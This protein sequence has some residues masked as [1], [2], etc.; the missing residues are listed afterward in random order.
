MKKEFL[1]FSKIHSKT[2]VQ[3]SFLLE[4]GNFIKREIP[5]QI[6]S[7]DF[8]EIFKKTFFTEDLPTTA[9]VCYRFVKNL[10]KALAQHLNF[11]NQC[12]N[13]ACQ[14]HLYEHQREIKS[15]LKVFI[16]E[17]LCYNRFQHSNLKVFFLCLTWQFSSWYFRNFSKSKNIKFTSNISIR[18]IP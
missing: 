11:Q 6:S 9:D 3:E 10:V 7:F 1:N 17:R 5:A 2:L 4:A 18:G 8:C 15:C 12:Q 13:L 14:C 16:F